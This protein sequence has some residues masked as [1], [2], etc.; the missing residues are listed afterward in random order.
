MASSNALAGP[1][2]VPGLLRAARQVGGVL[3]SLALTFLGLTAVTF[4]IGRV[5]PV[6]PVLAIVGDRAPAEVYDR[7]YLELGLDQPIWRQYL[8]FM[9]DLLRGDLG[10]S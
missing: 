2:R 7:V 1:G 9:G 10:V 6:D 3:G 8:L 5:M 4:F